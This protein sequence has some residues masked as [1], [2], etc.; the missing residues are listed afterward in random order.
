MKLLVL[1]NSDSEGAGLAEASRAWPWLAAAALECPPADVTHRRYFAMAASAL[2]FLERQLA[3]TS[4]DVVVVSATLYAFSMKT[5]ANRIEH[6]LGRRARLWAEARFN[7]FDR[8]TGQAPGRRVR[9]RLNT[10]A[11][12]LARHTIGT[13]SE[14][15][16][17]QVLEAYVAMVERLAR[18]EA[19]QVLVIGS[20]PF[21][22]RIERDNRRAASAQRQFNRRLGEACERR[23]VGW[24]DP[25]FLRVPGVD[26]L[27]NDA[28]HLGEEGHRLV[29]A[30]VLRRLRG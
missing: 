12:W 25:E 8:R 16:W 26:T 3:R 13:A 14:A 6:L 1:G 24:I 19:A 18:E 29:A 2:E 5:V 20:L 27:Y 28:L 21:T 23:R 9:P 17:Q 15:T 11:H 4:P 22:A 7:D 10:A 30:E